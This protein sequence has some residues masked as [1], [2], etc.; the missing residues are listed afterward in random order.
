MALSSSEEESIEALKRWWRESGRLLLA[1]IVAVVIVYAGWQL[2]Q[3]GQ[4][5]TVGQASA[6]YDQLTELIVLPQGESAEEADRQQA[7]QIIE[8][9]KNE[10][11]SSSYALYAALFGARLAVEDGDL[12][13]ARQELEWLL[14][15]TRSG[16]F[17]STEP[18]LIRIAQL[19]LA[20]VLLASGDTGSALTLVS[21]ADAGSMQAEFEELKGDIYMAQGQRDEA[22]VA[23]EAAMMAGNGSPVLQ[24]KLTELQGSR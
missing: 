17:S 11:S 8:R 7:R 5:R 4:S 1:G 21:S 14:D 6:L 19:R 16:L 20:E 9:I 10:Y 13:R 22:L 23:Y 2:F 18:T 12:S 24:M 3:S 15:N